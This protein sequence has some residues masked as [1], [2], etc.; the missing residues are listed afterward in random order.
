M[1]ATFRP[2][3]ALT[4]QVAAALATTLALGG[5]QVS[6]ALEKSALRD[7]RLYKL[8]AEPAAAS[9]AALTDVE[10]FTRLSLTG[11]YDGERQF[12]V[13][14][15]PGGRPQVVT[16]LVTAVGVFLVNRGWPSLSLDAAAVPAPSEQVAL[17]GVVWP[18]TPLSPA[19][20]Q[21]PWPVGWPKQVRAL[22][23]ARMAA[24]IESHGAYVHAMEIRLEPDNPGVLQAASLAWDYSPGTHWGYAAQWLLIGTAIGIGYAVIGRRRA[25][26]NDG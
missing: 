11:R 19:L 17:V 2:G 22:Q 4:L 1:R 7:A 23:P 21:A 20:A 10:D 16:P 18:A 12:L 15:R 14:N 24:A 5:W 26:R 9:A 6:R 13:V 3:C 8:R 25:Q